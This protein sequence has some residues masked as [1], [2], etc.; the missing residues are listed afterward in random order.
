MNIIKIQ[1][2]IFEIQ[3]ENTLENKGIRAI[4]KLFLNNVWGKFGQSTD[5]DN[6]EFINNYN[7]L[8]QRIT[9]KDIVT[10]EIDIINEHCVE[11]VFN[12]KNESVKDAEYISETTAVLLHLT[13]VLDYIIC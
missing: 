2:L 13:P 5:L 1:G 4:A 3:S 7:T 10:R 8:L 12:A 6:R 9:N 11:H